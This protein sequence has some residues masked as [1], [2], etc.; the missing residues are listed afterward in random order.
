MTATAT[1]S[2]KPTTEAPVVSLAESA[3]AKIASARTTL[4]VR[5]IE[6]EAEVDL[7]LTALVA[8]EHVLF[9]GPPGTGKSLL[10]DAIT[11]LVHG[12]RFSYLMT[13]FTDPSEVVGPI[14]LA[15]LKEGRYVRLTKGKLPA[16][17]V[18][19]LDEIFKSSS[20]I[21]NTLLKVLNER[22]F[23]DGNGLKS[24]PLRLC[25]AASNEWP[26]GEGHAELGAL[27]DRFV[28][29]R[30][31]RPIA[32]AAGLRRLRFGDRGPIG[33]TT[34]SAPMDTLTAGELDAAREEAALIPWSA[35][36][37]AAF[38]QIITELNR[39][40]IF[41][42]DRRQVK[43]VKVASA[44][45][46]LEGAAEVEPDHLTILSDVL[47]DSPEEQ[48]RKA[49]EVV[50]RVANPAGFAVNSLLVEVEQVLGAVDLKNIAKV[51]ETAQKLGEIAKKLEGMTG[52]AKADKART[53]VKDRIRA[54]KVA[55]YDAV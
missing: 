3:R 37:E 54:M 26:T 9:V 17:D 4:N 8:G 35:A 40:G 2:V 48:P 32:T 49:A 23:D 14:S 19:F 39:E 27:F 20:A 47:W 36:A 30:T 1:K 25:I 10:S 42:G 43:A 34:A 12:E 5:M 38:D 29:R 7:C 53:Y 33:S 13:K 44:A 11:E 51:T 45:A 55:A 41:P 24:I 31:V 16:A 6:R 21:L 18:V 28:I 46:W 15:D 22:K 52:N 50:G